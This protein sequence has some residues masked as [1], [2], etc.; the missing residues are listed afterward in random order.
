MK[1]FTILLL[2]EGAEGGG[3]YS[4]EINDTVGA[5]LF[6]KT[7]IEYPIFDVV[8]NECLSEWKIVTIFDVRN[9][10]KPKEPIKTVEEKNLPS[11]DSIKEALKLDI[12]NKILQKSQAEDE[13]KTPLPPESK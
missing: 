10:E 12:I 5:N 11:Y 9:I 13:L 3:H 6:S 7:I 1:N 8:P 2:A 4:A